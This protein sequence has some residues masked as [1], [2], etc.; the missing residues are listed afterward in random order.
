MKQKLLSIFENY[1]LDEFVRISQ[2]YG[3]GYVIKIKDGDGINHEYKGLPSVVRK[4]LSYDNFEMHADDPVYS[5]VK[6]EYSYTV[7]K[8]VV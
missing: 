6:G 1:G 4:A 3:M 5:E 2:K 8:Q 7:K